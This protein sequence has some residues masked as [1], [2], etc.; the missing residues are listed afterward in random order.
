[1][2]RGELRQR[3][4]V[5]DWQCKLLPP[6]TFDFI[7][8]SPPCTEYSIAKT[9]GTRNLELADS[10]VQRTMEIIDYFKPPLGYIIENPQTGLLKGRD[11]KH[12]RPYTDIDYC[13]N[14]VCRTERERDSGT[15]SK[16]AGKADP[17]AKETAD[18][19]WR[20]PA[21]MSRLLKNSHTTKTTHTTKDGQQ[22]NWVGCPTS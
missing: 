21:D 6:K 22:L 7:W 13:V 3:H 17:C 2:E 4:D 11:F 5:S 14:T 15:T 19:S 8:A 16:T 18:T 10:I 12:N 20:A 9:T 1:M